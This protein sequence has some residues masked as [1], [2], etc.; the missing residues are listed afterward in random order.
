MAHDD[1]A[2]TR[3]IAHSYTK[4]G[5]TFTDNLTH[6]TWQD[7]D[8]SYKNYN[9]ALAYCQ[10]LTLDGV[11]GWRL[12]EMRELQTLQDFS[13]HNGGTYWS[14]TE[15]PYN[16]SQMAYYINFSQGFSADYGS[17]DVFEKSK[18][19][20]VRCVKGDRL[21]KGK[22]TRDNATQTVSDT[23]THLMWEDTAHIQ[24]TSGVEDAIAYCENLTLGGYHDWHLPNINEYYTIA[25]R[26][27][28]DDA[29]A[30]IFEHKLSISD[31]NT[32][33]HYRAANYWTSTYY[34]QHPNLPQVH[35]YRTFNERDGASH[36]CRYYMGM[37]ARCVRGIK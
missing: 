1:G 35:Y 25:D 9:Q 31:D 17:R 18:R 36:R 11:A 5:K 30:D 22:F 13:K 24:Q 4:N 7:S 32:N 15:Y 2:T 26:S 28:Y 16:P 14:A 27:H 23:T 19:Y 34:G 21:S 3:G 6:L 8:I 12:P 29:V 20:R 37:H 10:G 33:E